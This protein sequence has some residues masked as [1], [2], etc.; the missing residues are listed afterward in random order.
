MYIV[1]YSS[2][3]TANFSKEFL[4]VL[5]LWWL[6]PLVSVAVLEIIYCMYISLNWQFDVWIGKEMDIH[7]LTCTLWLHGNTLKWEVSLKKNKVQISSGRSIFFRLP[8]SKDVVRS[9]FMYMDVRERECVNV[10]Q[11]SSMAS[12]DMPSQKEVH[13]IQTM[14]IFALYFRQ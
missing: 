11:C 3:I 12:W 14:T 4:A 2:E 10:P 5:S 8:W 6:A 7:L 13:F 1:Y 9:R